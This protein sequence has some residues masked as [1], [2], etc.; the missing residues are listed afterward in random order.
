MSKKNLVTTSTIGILTSILAFL[1]IVSCCGFPLI[2]AILAWIGIGATQLNFLS[3][4]RMLFSSIAIVAILYGFYQVYFKKAQ[5]EGQNLCC[6]PSVK[7]NVFAKLMLWIGLIAVISS[8]FVNNKENEISDTECCTVSIIEKEDLNQCC[9]S[10]NQNKKQLQQS[11]QKDIEQK[12]GCCS[13]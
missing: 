12:S 7:K 9:N 10:E 13:E 3:E 8:F 5:T 1:G 11:P 4:Y 2:A 6:K